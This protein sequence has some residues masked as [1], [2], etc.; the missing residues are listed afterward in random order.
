MFLTTRGKKPRILVTILQC[1]R[2][3]PTTK[4]YLTQNVSNGTAEVT[5]VRIKKKGMFLVIIV[6]TFRR[7]L[8]WTEMVR[9]SKKST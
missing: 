8:K 7:I 9:F 1:T 2:K 5:W 6:I 4:I 3:T